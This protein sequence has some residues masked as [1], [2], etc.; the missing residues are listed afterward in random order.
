VVARIAIFAVL[1]NIFTQNKV[2]II[3][4][5]FDGKS[6]MGEILLNWT[7]SYESNNSGFFVERSKDAITFENI[8]F[9]NSLAKNGNSNRP[10]NYSFLDK[11]AINGNYYR[12]AQLDFDGKKTTSKVIY[13]FNYVEEDINIETIFPNPARNLIN[14]T[15]CST[16]DQ[17]LVVQFIN[18]FGSV[19]LQESISMKQGMKNSPFSISRLMPG[20][21]YVKV[22]AGIPKTQLVKSFIV[23]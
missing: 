14:V 7:T 8:G 17:N 4:H 5:N 15:F 12:L 13:L 21:Y 11:S 19:V 20:K 18:Q 3:L 2:Y 6:H 16:N 9:L 22:F 23:Y 1:R 10:L